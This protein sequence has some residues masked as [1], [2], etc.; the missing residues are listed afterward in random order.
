[1]SIDTR[2]D[3]I[4][5]AA[6][7]RYQKKYTGIIEVYGGAW[8]LID[9]MHKASGYLVTTGGGVR[10]A[11]PMAVDSEPHL[12][13]LPYVLASLTSLIY[14]EN[15]EENHRFCHTLGQVSRSMAL[16]QMTD[17]QM[18]SDPVLLAESMLERASGSLNL[19]NHMTDFLQ[20]CCTNLGVDS[21][22]LTY[23]TSQI[24]DRILR[25][26]KK[27]HRIPKLTLVVIS[28]RQWLDLHTLATYTIG[29]K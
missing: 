23:F 5:Q 16:Y 11:L 29:R 22:L 19:S 3:R 24:N 15:K 14:R 10:F 21:I 12:G 28:P 26:L 13:V 7:E 6:E 1:M 2:V 9:A 20:S 18:T 27:L 4:F 8:D 17:Y 25:D